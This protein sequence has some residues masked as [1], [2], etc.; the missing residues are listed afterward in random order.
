MSSTLRAIC[1]AAV[2]ALLWP[3]HNEAGAADDTDAAGRVAAALLNDYAAQVEAGRVERKTWVAAEKRFTPGFKTRYR[4]AEKQ[5][6]KADPE[7][8]WSADPLLQAQDV[9]SG[10][11]RAAEMR[12]EPD[13]T[14]RGVLV[15]FKKDGKRL[16]EW[17][18]VPFAAVEV[19]GVWKVSA[20]GEIK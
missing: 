11:F 5:A 18:G 2:C 13:G 4:E 14:V 12:R 1:I 9:P 7:V 15:V 20:L 6:W 16:A 8:G 3:L 17:P 10:K 19:D